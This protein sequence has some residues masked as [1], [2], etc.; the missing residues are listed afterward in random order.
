MFIVGMLAFL[1][2]LFL[3]TK[4][5]EH[6]GGEEANVLKISTQIIAGIIAMNASS[7]VA[8]M[9]ATYDTIINFSH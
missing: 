6:M 8:I 7:F 2:G 5:G 4:L 9:S 1:R 3:L